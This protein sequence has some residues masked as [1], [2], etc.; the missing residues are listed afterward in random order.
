M[1]DIVILIIHLFDAELQSCTIGRTAWEEMSTEINIRELAALLRAKRGTTGLRAIAQEITEKCGPVSSSTLSRVEQGNVPDLD[2][3]V[4]LCRWLD[5]TTE[6]LM[7][8]GRDMK[9][10]QAPDNT[11]EVVK[12]HLRADRTLDPTTAEALAKMIQLAYDAAKSGAI[13]R[14]RK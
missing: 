9:R 2:T 12:A 5:V 8:A 4:R 7:F 10:P 13:S 1:R 11:A 3:F 14:K 6:R